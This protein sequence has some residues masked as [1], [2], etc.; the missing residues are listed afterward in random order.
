[1]IK[2]SDTRSQPSVV[3]LFTGAGGLDIGLE[4]AGFHT[5]AAVDNEADCIA[6]LAATQKKRVRVPRGAGRYFS[7][8]RTSSTVGF[9]I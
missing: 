2:H 8:A 7:K 5:V 1:M 3:S 6:T 9:K 4:M